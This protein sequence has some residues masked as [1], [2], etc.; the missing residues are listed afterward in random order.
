[1]NIM[2]QIPENALT[3]D[4]AV[5][6]QNTAIHDGLVHRKIAPCTIIAQ[7]VKGRYEVESGGYT[8]I[9]EPGGVFLATAGEP[10]CIS[11]HAETEGGCMVARWLHAR[12]LIHG[13]I[14]FARLLAM[15]RTISAANSKTL[16]NIIGELLN[17]Q[18]REATLHDVVQRNALALQALTLLCGQSEHSPQGAALLAGTERLL[19]V[20]S[21]IR[22]HLADA[23]TVEDLVRSA[24]LSRSRLHTLFLA[25]LNR[26]PMEYV[27]GQR[28]AQASR[29]L[30][31]TDTTIKEIAWL[32]GFV[33][34]YH[35]S[36]EF[37]S[38]T[39]ESP[40]Q[41]RRHHKGLQ[42]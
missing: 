2:K 11:H 32:C 28:I 22:N 20:L 41:Y 12:Y 26:S 1:M 4:F 19:P 37:K 23:I 31:F 36:R 15:P 13:T 24:G 25:Y 34:P 5:A 10:L 3:L 7:A 8:E 30:L 33:N 9:T 35:F 29:Q 40:L 18:A 21:Y 17:L 42:V 6:G 27:K 16:G 39:G 38:A 14:D